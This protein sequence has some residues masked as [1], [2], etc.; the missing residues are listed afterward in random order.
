MDNDKLDKSM[1]MQ[2]LMQYNEEEL[3]YREYN[4]LQTDEKA[5]NFFLKQYNSHDLWERRIYINEMLPKDHEV[6]AS[7]TAM[8]DN[9]ND[10][11]IEK[12]C[13]FMPHLTA[14]HDYFEIVYVVENSMDIDLGEKI[15][16]LK[17]GDVCFIS[18]GIRHSPHIM[19]K[20]IALQMIVRKS[21]FHQEF[22]RCLTGNSVISD[23]FLNAL[24][25][26]DHGSILV[27]HL[28]S[29]EEIKSIFFTIYQENYNKNAQY[30]IIINSSFEI[31][32]CYLLRCNSSKTEIKQ[33]CQGTDSRITQILQCIE[34]NYK[35]ITIADL[36][37][38]F[39]L[40]R[41]YLSKYIINKTGK[42]FSA[43]LQDIR[44]E[45]ACNMLCSSNLRVEDITDAAGYHNVEHFIR[46]FKQK[47]NKT[48]TQFR[49]SK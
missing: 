31:L 49:K 23:F 43:I 30:Q 13:R 6:F 5:L 20:T 4:T 11:Y 29:D 19:K 35:K 41:P 40:S 26:Q 33:I 42:S 18:P 9:Q 21:T 38:K 44:L 12:Y 25:L 16:T 17:S 37:Q 22:F 3:F 24:Y 45:K 36:S 28:D 27:F 1:V 15:I 10:I 8:W 14:V 46:L 7:E 39:H 32:L 34:N 2:H 47:Y 48:P